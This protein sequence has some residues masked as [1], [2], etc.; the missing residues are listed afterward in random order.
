[1]NRFDP[2]YAAEAGTGSGTATAAPAPDPAAAAAAATATGAKPNGSAEAFYKPWNLGREEVD[3][4]EGHKF[5]DAGAMIKSARH[6]ETI[7]RDKNALAKP[8][9]GKEKDWQ[10][11]ELLGWEPDVNKYT[12][13]EVKDLPKGMLFDQQL[14][15]DLR[16]WAYDSKMP[17]SMARDARRLIIDGNR[18]LYERLA[19]DGAKSQKDLK[20]AL[21]KE[22]GADYQT[23][24]ELARR[25]METAGAGEIEMSELEAAFGAPRVIKLFHKL[26]TMIGEQQ[27]PSTG[28][29]PGLTPEAARGERLRLEG[30]REWMKIFTDARNPQ[31]QGHVARRNQLI[32]LEAKGA[33]L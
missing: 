30:D 3:W 21:I 33:H 19:G 14:D 26:A 8:E 32:E 13:D 11:W 29:S 20:E 5:G 1:M 28:G 18:R 31:H 9:K 2:V 7:A 6:F 4:I 16:K 24:S 23:N 10:G 27:L 22:W 25:A 15:A 17:L 12:F